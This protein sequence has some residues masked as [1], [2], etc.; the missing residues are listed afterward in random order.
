[1][2]E[3]HTF[4]DLPDPTTPMGLAD[5][6]GAMARGAARGAYRGSMFHLAVGMGSALL[7]LFAVV[8]LLRL[9]G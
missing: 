6:Y 5:A 3:P 1:M 7:V 9:H 2:E 4:A 8:L